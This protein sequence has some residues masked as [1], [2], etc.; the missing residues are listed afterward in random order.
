MAQSKSVEREIIFFSK[1]TI[2]GVQ[3]YYHNI[4]S[5]DPYKEFEKTWIFTNYKYDTNT[6][7]PEPYNCCKEIVFDYSDDETIYE[8]A[9][10]L[11]KHISDKEGVI[12]TN[13]FTELATLHIYRKRNKTIFFVCHDVD[14]LKTA[15]EFEFLIDVFIAHNEFFYHE[16][17]KLFP[18]RKNDIYYLP[19]G[20]KITNLKRNPNYNQPLN[21]V[22]IARLQKEKG[23]YDLP[24]IDDLLK[25]KGIEVTWTIIG[26]GPEKENIMEKV[27][28]RKNFSFAT[29]ANTDGVL[30]LAVQNDVFILPSVLDGL[31]V[32][33]LESMS[34]GVVPLISEFN[35]GIKKVVTDQEG[36]VVPV[37]DIDT[38]VSKIEDL[39]LHRDKLETLSEAAL[40]KVHTEYSNTKR[41]Q[42][43]YDL[44]RRYADLK[45]PFRY[46]RPK[47]GNIIHQLRVPKGIRRFIKKIIS[48]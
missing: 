46:V 42:A 39:H 7:L 5:N 36:F 34:L 27:K 15:S 29:P 31:P 17:I 35:P 32:A 44:F 12:M 11:N 13:T 3:N 45:K 23:I 18:A 16:L 25:Q 30:Q 47:Y 4:V 28:D 26:G 40:Q 48:K 24:V 19:Y 22:F 14:Y 21:I 20:V 2:G 43:Y 10:R 41:A 37:G 8:I 1:Y 6:K 33:L 38:F 9:R